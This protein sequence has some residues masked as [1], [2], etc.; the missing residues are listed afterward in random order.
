MPGYHI[1]YPAFEAGGPPRPGQ[2]NGCGSGT[3]T[4]PDQLSGFRICLSFLQSVERE[5]P[6]SCAV[7]V[8]LHPMR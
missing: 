2:P 1:A 3:G 8:L 6:S 4:Q 7:S 5:M